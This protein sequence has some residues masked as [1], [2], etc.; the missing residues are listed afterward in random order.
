MDHPGRRRAAIVAIASVVAASCIALGFWQL[1]RLAE[2]R[3]LNSRIL[4][5]RDATPVA[6]DGAN[7]AAGS[8]RPATAEGAYDVEREV[9]VYGR[10][11]DGEAGHHVVTPLVLARRRC[12]SSSSAVG[13][14][15]RRSRHPS[16]APPHPP[17]PSACGACSFPTKATVLSR[18]MRAESSGRWTWPASPRPCRTTW[19]RTRS[20]WPSRNRPNRE[21]CRCP[22]P[23]PSSRRARTCRTRSNGSSFAAV[24]I[25]GAAILVRRE[26]RLPTGAP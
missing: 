13:S 9:L 24:A 17:G 15:S 22:L 3:D 16:P 1:A 23:S 14:R 21:T 10:S 2:R 5:R 26:K 11:L 20:S 4:D 25:V 12:R 19:P 7:T 8:F 6:I 18:L